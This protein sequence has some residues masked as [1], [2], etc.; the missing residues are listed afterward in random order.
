M[1]L[2]FDHNLSP[3]LVERLAGLYPGSAHPLA[4]GLERAADTESWSYARKYEFTIVTRDAD[5]AEFSVLQTAPPKVI[6][7]RMGNRSTSQIETALRASC[8]AIA[9]FHTDPTG[10]VLALL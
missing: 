6:W 3:Y 9:E 10:F 1:K 2:L 5:Y 4:V 8:E 7:L